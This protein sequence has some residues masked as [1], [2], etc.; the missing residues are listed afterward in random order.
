MTDDQEETT[1]CPAAVL[2]FCG[3]MGAAVMAI[4]TLSYMVV[5]DEHGTGAE[6]PLPSV[7]Q[8]SSTIDAGSSV[9]FRTTSAPPD[10][11]FPIE[12]CVFL[13]WSGDQFTVYLLDTCRTAIKKKERG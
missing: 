11:A 2:A 9:V 6:A 4:A 1:H 8:P 5:V 7:S 10:T 13:E 12:E 3:I